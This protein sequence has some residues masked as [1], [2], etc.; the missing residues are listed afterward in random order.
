MRE[1]HPNSEL[2]TAKELACPFCQEELPGKK[3]QR[4]RHVGGHMEEI[5]L[6][7]IT[8][9]FEENW[10]FYS[11]SEKYLSSVCGEEPQREKRVPESKNLTPT[12]PGLP[13]A[14]EGPI[15]APP[16]VEASSAILKEVP[17]LKQSPQARPIDTK[18]E[19]WLFKPIDKEK[20]KQRRVALYE[21]LAKV[22][23]QSAAD[24]SSSITA[25]ESS[26]GTIRKTKEFARTPAALPEEAAL[27]D[28]EAKREVEVTKPFVGNDPAMHSTT[29]KPSSRMAYVKA[30]AEVG[31]TSSQPPKTITEAK[32]TEKPAK[33]GKVLKENIP[34]PKPSANSTETSQQTSRAPPKKDRPR[35]KR[36]GGASSW[37]NWTASSSL[38]KAKNT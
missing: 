12:S 27:I 28:S 18:Q 5:A 22:L 32:K 29:S 4:L 37:G 10:K 13:S 26:H 21:E 23:A 14:S 8:G 20:R 30:V 3:L 9:A 34:A 16:E 33:R 25:A 6:S 19:E 2:L 15:L 38:R 35:I 17:G 31:R 36:T 1:Q 7:A 24:S 11:D